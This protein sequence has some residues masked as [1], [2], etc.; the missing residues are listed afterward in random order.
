MGE[1]KALRT[2]GKDVTGFWAW[3]EAKVPRSN[4]EEGGRSTQTARP[5]T[6]QPL[7][8]QLQQEPPQTQG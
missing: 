3:E 7:R 4:R 1:E 2:G 5:P 8:A 6:R